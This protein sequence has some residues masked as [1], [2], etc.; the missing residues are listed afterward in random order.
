MAHHNPNKRLAAPTTAT[1]NRT[2]KIKPSDPISQAFE[3]DDEWTL[4]EG[5]GGVGRRTAYT[6][7]MV[8]ALE[9]PGTII[10]MWCHFKNSDKNGAAAMVGNI[11]LQHERSRWFREAEANGGHWEA[12]CGRIEEAEVGDQ[13]PYRARLEFVFYKDRK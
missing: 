8:Y 3:V 2:M 5:S 10:R 7:A 13:R 1:R 9:N 11:T 4:Q 6:E 12:R